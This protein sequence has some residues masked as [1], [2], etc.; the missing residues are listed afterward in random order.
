M[1]VVIVFI[2]CVRLFQLH[3]FAL[4]GLPGSAFRQ[5]E[6]RGEMLKLVWIGLKIGLMSLSLRNLGREGQVAHTV[7]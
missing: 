5:G 4:T 3:Q 6:M 2:S 7:V 1:Q